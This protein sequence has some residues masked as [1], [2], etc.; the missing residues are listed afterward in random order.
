MEGNAEGRKKLEEIYGK[1]KLRG[2]L[3]DLESKEWMKSNCEKCPQCRTY[4]E[5]ITE[6]L[7]AAVM[8]DRRNI[9]FSFV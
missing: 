4:I 9:I 3:D 8:F 2:L 1:Q 7:L 6:I 5:V